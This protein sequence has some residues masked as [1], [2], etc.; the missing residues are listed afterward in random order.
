MRVTEQKKN[1][2]ATRTWKVYKL[3]VIP[4]C[5]RIVPFRLGY[6]LLKTKII[7]NKHITPFKQGSPQLW[8]RFPVHKYIKPVWLGSPQLWTQT[9]AHK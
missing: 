9:P 3:G 1:K 8:T 6:P 5:K 4:E 7:M 2:H